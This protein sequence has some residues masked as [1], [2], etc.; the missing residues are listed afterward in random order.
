MSRNYT[1]SAFL[2]QAALR[3][4]DRPSIVFEDRRISY[5]ELDELASRFASGLLAHGLAPG[6]RVG[7]YMT[8]YPEWVIAF[9]G[10]A[11][12]GGVI[13]PMNSR[14]RSQEV[15]Y[16][17][18]NCEAAGL[19]IASAFLKS[20]YV[21]IVDAVW[22][23]IPS[24]RQVIVRGDRKT[25]RMS[26]L[27]DILKAGE[28]HARDERLSTVRRAIEPDDVVFILYTSGTT[29]E[30]KGAMLTNLNIARNGEQIAQVMRQDEN[31]LTLIAVPFFHCFGCVIGITASVSAASGILPLP[32]FERHEALR[33]IERH[34]ATVV[35]GVP[36]M[37]IEYLE[38]LKEK[39]YDVRSVRTGVMAGAPCP[40]E[41][42]RAAYDRMGANIV[43]AY[44]LTEASPV[45][46]MTQ[47]DDSFEDRVA[48]VGRALPE[49]EVRIVDDHRRPLP[50]NSTG[51]LAVRGYNVMKGY[52]GNGAATAETIDA[53]GWLYSGDLATMDE[54]GYIRIVGR[55]KEMYITGGFNVYPREIEEY[56]FTHPEVANVAVIGVPD[57]RFGEV[58]WAI[59]KLAQGGQATEEELIA[60]CRDKIANFK[61]PKRVV[62]VDSF[63]MTQSGKIQKFRL[64]EMAGNGE[65]AAC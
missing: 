37:F 26:F 22:N 60:F 62:F 41:V 51:E 21:A 6:D 27:A 4:P 35:H 9:F 65:L 3:F 42:M 40:I 47:L 55:K 2:E 57:P 23:E 33:A 32:S 30:P 7:L 34:R 29:G 45:I 31:D 24:L 13:V 5:A 12:M 48:T 53:A 20:D 28:G 39:S 17:L 8:N 15:A 50:G 52:Y 11:R 58:G 36:T 59:V 61:V 46:T 38:G 1:L 56:L 19:V 18:N 63:P 54:R 49:Q 43:I 44:G 14:Y 16:I 64:R 25:P 10:I